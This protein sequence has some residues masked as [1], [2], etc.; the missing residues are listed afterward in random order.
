MTRITL[1]LTSNVVTLVKTEQDCFKELRE[2]VNLKL[3][4]D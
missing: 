3:I 2:T 4:T 1:K